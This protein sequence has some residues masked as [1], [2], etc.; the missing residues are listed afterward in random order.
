M[1]VEEAIRRIKNCRDDHRCEREEA[2]FTLMKFAERRLAL[3]VIEETHD[4]DSMI[5]FSSP[6]V[7]Y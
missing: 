2:C 4:E 7:E 6:T 3:D 1:T 5:Y